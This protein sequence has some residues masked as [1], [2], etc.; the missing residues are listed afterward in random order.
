MMLLPGWTS[1]RMP[2]SGY[3]ASS[4]A[5]HASQPTGN[6][7]GSCV[8]EAES[9]ARFKVRSKVLASGT[10]FAF[11]LV[12]LDRRRV[13]LPRS[14][15]ACASHSSTF[16]RSSPSLSEDRLRHPAVAG[17]GNAAKPRCNLTM[18]ERTC[19][20]GV[21]LLVLRHSKQ[22]REDCKTGTI[23]CPSMSEHRA[24]RVHA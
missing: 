7:R 18:K 10:S 22:D 24:D 4:H 20:A 3:S 23:Y 13:A 11:L 9:T 17:D 16:Q 5:A 8:A 19:S 15:Q 14:T 2:S 6:M 1:P 12:Q 21:R